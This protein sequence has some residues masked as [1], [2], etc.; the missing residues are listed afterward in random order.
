MVRTIVKK[1]FVPQALT[2]SLKDFH[3]PI[4]L[5]AALVLFGPSVLSAP[6]KAPKITLVYATAETSTSAAVVWNTNTASDSLLQY[7]TSSPIPGNAPQVYV[8]TPVTLHNIPVAGLTPG[9]LYFYKVTSCTKRG[10]V[11]AT[12]SFETFPV[13]PDVVPP[14]SGSW[15][16][17]S[18]PNISGP[19]LLN[20]ELMGVAAVSD[21]S[22]WAVGWA[23]DPD[24]SYV[25]RTLI[26]HF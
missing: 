24:P 20:N 6:A 15:Q 23:Q 17:V 7:S 10:C 11:T 12:G 8:A 26:Q 19:T 5:L 22:V 3:K 25:K 2:F 21:R 13:C 14:V 18:S 1:N 16:K 4:A 9:A